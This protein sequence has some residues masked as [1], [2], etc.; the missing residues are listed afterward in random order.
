MCC[1]SKTG[2]Y[3]FLQLVKKKHI[4]LSN[5]EKNVVLSLAFSSHKAVK[6]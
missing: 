2:C 3:V 1:L 4:F 5:T 6:S